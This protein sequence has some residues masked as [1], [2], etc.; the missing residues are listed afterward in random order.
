M[1][2]SSEGTVEQ[3][4]AQADALLIPPIPAGMQLLDWQMGKEAAEKA[5]EFTE[6][7][8]LSRGDLKA[9]KAV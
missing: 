8:I 7:A 6:T 2:V 5:R 4:L 9:M 1:V 3:S